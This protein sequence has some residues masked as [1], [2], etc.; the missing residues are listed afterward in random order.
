MDIQNLVAIVTGGASG[1]GAETAKTLVQMGAKVAILDMNEEDGEKLSQELGDRALFF[2]VNVTDKDQIETAV[3]G[4]KESF[5]YF[6]VVVNCA[7][8]GGRVPTVEPSDIDPLEWFD[9]HQQINLKGTYMVT[10]A[11]VSLMK[12]NPSNEEGERG[13]IVNV[14][15]VAALEGQ[16]GHAAYSSSKGGVYAMTLPLAR[17]FAQY[18]IRIMTICPGLFDT[19]MTANWTP[20]MRQA[21]AESIAF[22]KR[23]GKLSEFTSLVSHIIQNPYLNGECIRLDGG[24]RG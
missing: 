12:D 4:V 9:R 16:V 17:E 6:H 20:E 15:S 1:L 2:Q 11:A 23:P 10:R 19:A 22:P 8:I 14:S 3:Q 24:L 7:G 18:G 21:A 13:V 5:G